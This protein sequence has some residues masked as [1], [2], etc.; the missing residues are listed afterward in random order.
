MQPA[1]DSAGLRCNGA[2][3]ATSQWLHGGDTILAGDSRISV[4]EDDGYV[5]LEVTPVGRKTSTW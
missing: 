3:V 2:L 5:L 1:E 4:I